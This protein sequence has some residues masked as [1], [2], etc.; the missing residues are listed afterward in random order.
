M[1]V[2]SF[3]NVKKDFDEVLKYLTTNDS[4]RY[5]LYIFGF[6]SLKEAKENLEALDC[7]E[8]KYGDP[9]YDIFKH[10]VYGINHR[11]FMYSLFPE[12][13]EPIYD[14]YTTKYFATDIN[15]LRQWVAEQET[16]Q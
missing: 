7:G 12:E 8:D 10:A 1:P 5:G 11:G 16:Q 9:V 15:S 4:E 2:F 13:P 6:N 3:D 14:C